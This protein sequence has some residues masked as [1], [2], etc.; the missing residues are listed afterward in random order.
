MAK[1]SWHWQYKSKHVV[2]TA[3]K[4]NNFSLRK[5]KTAYVHSSMLGRD[6]QQEKVILD[7]NSIMDLW[8]SQ[9]SIRDIFSCKE[10]MT[11]QV[12]TSK[13]TNQW[14]M[15]RPYGKFK[16]KQEK[17]WTHV[18]DSFNAFDKANIMVHSTYIIMVEHKV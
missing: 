3:A 18:H 12:L 15:F 5:S 1:P 7:S 2:L 17:Q 16:L 9:K 4:S 11:W 8:S 10:N 14:Q 13:K 6:I